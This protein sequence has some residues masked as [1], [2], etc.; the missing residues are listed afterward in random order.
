MSDKAVFSV[1]IPVG[2]G[3]SVSVTLLDQVAT[4]L[5]GR[6]EIIIANAAGNIL[7]QNILE[8]QQRHNIRVINSE[9]GRATQLNKAADSAAGTFLWFVHA[10]SNLAEV[11]SDGLQVV[12]DHASERRLWYFDLKFSDAEVLP[13]Q[14]NEFG[15]WWRCRFL[16]MPFGDQGFLI[17]KK[18]F[19]GLG[20]YPLGQPYGE[21]HLFV[22]QARRNSFRISPIGQ[23]LSTSARGYAQT[24]W[25]RQTL[26]YLWW[27]YKQAIPAALRLH[28][29]INKVRLEP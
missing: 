9:A 22:W 11:A 29:A 15:V 16:A 7:A 2:P 20:Q 25:L 12:I 5:A 6:G 26:R 1:I 17:E 19:D 28:P 13:M 4:L 21:D 8:K 18:F 23:V 3:D 14:I 24:G 10:D 27:T